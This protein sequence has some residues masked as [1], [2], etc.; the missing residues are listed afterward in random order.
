[1]GYGERSRIKENEKEMRTPYST[2]PENLKLKYVT[3]NKENLKSW[4]NSNLDY[5]SEEYA[6][7]YI[8]DGVGGITYNGQPY[9]EQAD[10]FY[11]GAE[12]ILK[13]LFKEL[14]EDKLEI[15]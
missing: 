8:D 12:F 4:L 10:A 9:E 1:M 2:D 13:S 14:E 5:Y 6:P 7:Q 3:L 11:A 15:T